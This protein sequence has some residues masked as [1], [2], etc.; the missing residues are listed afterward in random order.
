MIILYLVLMLNTPVSERSQV[1]ILLAVLNLA[2]GLFMRLDF[3]Y[4]IYFW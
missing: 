2:I 3:Y 4:K 1:T